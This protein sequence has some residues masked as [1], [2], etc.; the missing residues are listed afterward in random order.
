MSIAW[1]WL[2]ACA[3]LNIAADGV[4]WLTA[5]LVPALVAIPFV[6]YSKIKRG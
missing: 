6:V 4:W 3:V 2:A 1:L 5:S